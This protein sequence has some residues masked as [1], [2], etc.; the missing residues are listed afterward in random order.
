METF[1]LYHLAVCWSGRRVASKAEDPPLATGPVHP[2]TN[3]PSSPVVPRSAIVSPES[4]IRA[5]AAQMVFAARK[6]Q[7]FITP[8]QVTELESWTGLVRTVL[9][10]I[11]RHDFNEHA[12]L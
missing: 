8:D 3:V 11:S 2:I 12:R 6:S 7:D 5:A 4:V 1:H 10:F 9:R